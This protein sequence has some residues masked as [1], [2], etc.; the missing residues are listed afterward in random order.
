MFLHAGAAGVRPSAD[1][2]ARWNC[3][4]PLPD[5][6]AGFRRTLERSRCR[7]SVKRFD[8]I[9]LRLGR[10]ADGFRRRRSST[11]IQA[12]CARHRPAG[13]RASAAAPRSSASGLHDALRTLLPE[14]PADDYPRAG[15]ALSPPLSGAATHEICRCSPACPSCIARAARRAAAS[16]RWPPARAALRPRPGARQPAAWRRCF[17]ATRCADETH[18]KPHPAMLLE[19]M[20]GTRRRARAHR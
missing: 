14:L 5:E 9:D 1:G 6:L 16:W 2:R 8:L 4:A 19:L 10:H 11:A 20:D 13:R 3:E 12:A 18:S 15:R 17:D 7:D